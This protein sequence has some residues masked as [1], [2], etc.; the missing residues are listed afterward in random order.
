MDAFSCMRDREDGCALVTGSPRWNCGDSSFSQNNHRR[1]VEWK[2]VY[3]GW[4]EADWRVKPQWEME[5]LYSAY[6]CFPSML[7]NFGCL[8]CFLSWEGW[9][10]LIKKFEYFLVDSISLWWNQWSAQSRMILQRRVERHGT[11]RI[12]GVTNLGY[13]EIGVLLNMKH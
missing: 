5:V 7:L 9:I 12:R 2:Q 8:M 3:F 4:Q 1:C 10:I 6:F 13:H 11:S